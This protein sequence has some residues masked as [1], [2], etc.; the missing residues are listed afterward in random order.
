MR[1]IKHLEKDAPPWAHPRLSAQRPLWLPL[2]A[3]AFFGWAMTGSALADPTAPSNSDPPSISGDAVVGGVL[4]ADPGTWTGDDPITYAYQWS[5]GGTDSTDTLSAADVGQYMTV[6][7][8]ATNDAGSASVTTDGYGPVLPPAP[9]IEPNGAPVVSG[10]VQQGET[11]SVSQG[12]WSNSPTAFGY[13]WEDCD[14]SGN[15]CVAI[16]GATSSSYTLQPSDV[17]G[18]VLAVVSAANAG[19]NTSA[20]SAHH[21]TDPAGH[22]F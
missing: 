1:G 22:S 4:T 17:G 11:L 14:G 18:T 13:Q 7:V 15:N 3:V 6:T 2:L 20:T 16:T 9:V 19:G 12:S 10:L 21:W 5:D 8:T